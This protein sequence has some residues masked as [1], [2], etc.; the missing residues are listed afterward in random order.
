MSFVIEGTCYV[1]ST[2]QTMPFSQKDMQKRM[3]MKIFWGQNFVFGMYKN[4]LRLKMGTLKSCISL[5]TVL[6]G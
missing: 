3:K 2:R 4:D 6:V 1:L 5:V